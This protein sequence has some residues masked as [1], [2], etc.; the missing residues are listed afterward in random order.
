MNPHDVIGA[1]A[2]AREAADLMVREAVGRLPILDQTKLVGIVTRSNLLGA[3]SI[4][5]ASEQNVRRFRM[6]GLPGARV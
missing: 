1:D 3:H 5:L 4:R 6:I 2:T